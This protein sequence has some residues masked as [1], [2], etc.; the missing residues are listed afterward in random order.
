MTASHFTASL[1]C[2][3]RG[4]SGFASFTKDRSAENRFGPGWVLDPLVVM[5]VAIAISCLGAP[6]SSVAQTTFAQQGF[7]TPPV[8]SANR[9]NATHS[10]AIP[11]GHTAQNHSWPVASSNAS[12]PNAS[13]P[14]ASVSIP[15]SRQSHS[16]TASSAFRR[17]RPSEH[18]TPARVT[19]TRISPTHT[20]FDHNTTSPRS[21]ARTVSTPLV[22]SSLGSTDGVGAS[23]R[24]DATTHSSDGRLASS[25]QTYRTN[26]RI[27]YNRNLAAAL[28]ATQS[29]YRQ[30]NI[31]SARRTATHYHQMIN[32][33]SPVVADVMADN[34]AFA[35]RW[36]DLAEKYL[37][38]S[39]RVADRRAQYDA[40]A[41]DYDDVHAKLDNYG[42]TPTIGQF[43]QTKK[44]QLDVSQ[45]ENL[46]SLF[47][48]EELKSTRENQL[49]LE[50]NRISNLDEGKQASFL[51]S[52]SGYD[53]HD[54]K[55]AGLVSQLRHLL[56]ER[57]RW[58]HDLQTGYRDYQSKL[59]EFDS[60]TT[61]SAALANDYRKLINQHI[62]WIRSSDAISAKDFRD[63]KG[64][65]AALFDSNRSADFGPTLQRKLKANSVA[66]IGLLAMIVFIMILRWYA[67]TW[68]IGI[69]SRKK[70]RDTMDHSRKAA[71]SFLT[72][73]V[74]LAFPTIL[75]CLS[76]WLGS[77][78]VSESTLYASSAFAAAALV[79]LLVEICR[80]LI[81]KHGFI[82]KHVDVDLPDN[83]RATHYLTL[84]GFGLVV[85]AYTV[86]LM[87]SL[88]H[89]IWRDSVARFGFMFSML[90]VAMTAHFTLRPSGGFAEPLIA[91]FGGSV[92]HRVRWVIYLA[93]IGFP[94]AMIALMALGYAFTAN[95][96]IRRAII[97]LTAVLI[98]AT[99]WSLVKILSSQA[100]LTLTGSEKVKR[101]FD[102]YGPINPS[103]GLVTGTLA[104][105]SL[106]LKHHLAF[107]CQCALV[108]GVIVC[109]G[110]LW[111]DV[112]PNVR[113]GNPVV[114]TVQDTVTHASVDANGQTFVE[115]IH[116]DHLVTAMHLLLAAVTLWVAFQLA[117]LLPALFDALVLQRVSFDEGMEH[118]SLV[119]GRSLL[120]GAGCLVACKFL[121]V[122]WQV[123]QW[124]AVGLT[125]GLG[126][127]LQ[128]MVRNLF[129]GL[130]VLFEKPARLGDLI[131]VGKVTGRVASQK[132]RTTVLS[133][134]DG[135]EVIIPNKNFVS[136]DVVNWMG[137]GRLKVVAIEVAATRDERP[138][139]LCRSL[140][141]LAL[142][143]PDVLITPAPQATLVCVGKRSQRIEVRVWVEEDQNAER[144]T[145]Q[146]LKV[147]RN[148]LRDRSWW[149]AN[150]PSQPSPS[151]EMGD[152]RSLS[153][154]RRK[155]SA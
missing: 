68:L 54:T 30:E 62:T 15:S 106:E 88:D 76:R 133:D 110:W 100:W 77:G 119:I 21:L 101:E 94:L 24:N 10:P 137:A 97:T 154:R 89:G 118:F 32:T 117:K 59:G 65:I 152:T 22:T 145:E 132:L 41:R 85:A 5:C 113:M 98:G 123:I 64:G 135:R 102:E 108:L 127:G 48:S 115:T 56:G 72:V 31:D 20:T 34:I 81:R 26:S 80:Q 52:E 87:G 29:P 27:G 139:D 37:D 146:L 19:P 121:G 136:E 84:V 155:R 40:T 63:L 143:Q 78:I 67:K 144:F 17:S 4:K 130:V 95:E 105:H 44:E 42:L 46:Q 122:R 104:E 60:I 3:Q 61:E 103:G 116:Q 140:Q 9:S 51:L 109:F 23:Y 141:E 66:A 14:N 2:D 18:V 36:A 99:L 58:T 16:P 71:A 138:A 25:R 142:E 43:L 90:I 91:K 120:F 107:L 50:I 28:P 39:R 70:M 151:D 128:D 83:Q 126:F 45:A 69:G 53:P 13:S 149:V 96:L 49:D 7:S 74:A 12:S 35:N 150:Q 112:F 73:V 38:L 55:N 8:S 47:V 11:S 92:I 111:I 86:T 79:M 1:R 147:T 57:T 129:G 82:D 33:A 93:A 114:W 148:Y 153:K 125:I 75:Y 6:H 124:L 134:D 131:T